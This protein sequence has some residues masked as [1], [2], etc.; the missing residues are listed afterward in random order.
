MFHENIKKYRLDAKLDQVEFANILGVS[1]QTISAY[2][3]GNR[4]PTLEGLQNILNKLNSS[5][6]LDITYNDLLDGG[7]Q[8]SHNKKQALAQDFLDSR[9]VLN[10][11]STIDHILNN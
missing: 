2:E 6:N 11:K 7:I 5:L 8:T 3:S 9:S 10:G 4:T 1:M